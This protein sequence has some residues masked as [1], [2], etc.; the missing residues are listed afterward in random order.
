MLK[1]TRITDQCITS[2]P[3]PSQQ[4]ISTHL[5]TLQSICGH[6]PAPDH[7][8]FVG[9][10]EPQDT[11][12]VITAAIGRKLI[13]LEGVHRENG[14]LVGI[15][16]WGNSGAGITLICPEAPDHAS[17]VAAEMRRLLPRKE[18]TND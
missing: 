2:L 3:P 6:I 7:D 17:R 18:S 14:H 13:Q 9:Y 16:L 12:E 8:G 15:V 10:V 4:I 5:L 1:F 11:P